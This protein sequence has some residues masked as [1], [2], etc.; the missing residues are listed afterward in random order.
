M[1]HILSLVVVS[2]LLLSACGGVVVVRG[3]INFEPAI[4][5]GVVSI[6]HL[7]FVAT[8]NGKSDTVTVVTLLQTGSAQDLTF[9]G[10]QVT[11]FPVNMFVT[12]KYTQ[13]QPCSTLI[14]VVATH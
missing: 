5:S 13:G 3:A 4:A 11:Q 12:A 6:V 7:T 8:P 1:W 2:S 9:C 14:S 10:S